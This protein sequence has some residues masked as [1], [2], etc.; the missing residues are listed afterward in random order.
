[1]IGFVKGN[2]GPIREVPT[3]APLSSSLAKLTSRA[4]N[5]RM[6]LRGDR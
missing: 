1:M 2:R 4:N 6:V 3:L 5:A